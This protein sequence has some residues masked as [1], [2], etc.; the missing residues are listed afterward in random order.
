MGHRRV[1]EKKRRPNVSGL[2]PMNAVFGP[3]AP[4]GPTMGGSFFQATPGSRTPKAGSLNRFSAAASSW[5]LNEHTRQC[6]SL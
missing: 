6:F 5:S 2:L 1:E 4:G 3:P